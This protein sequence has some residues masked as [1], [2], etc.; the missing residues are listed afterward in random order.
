MSTY[1][2]YECVIEKRSK[3]LWKFMKLFKITAELHLQVMIHEL[4][5]EGEYDHETGNVI[6]EDSCCD[7]NTITINGNHFHVITDS[8]FL[9][10]NTTYYKTLLLPYEY[11]FHDVDEETQYEILKHN[12]LSSFKT[13]KYSGSIDIHNDCEVVIFTVSYDSSFLQFEDL[14]KMNDIDDV[15]VNEKEPEQDHERRYRV[16]LALAEVYK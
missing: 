9:D 14:L 10:P 7:N 6:Y 5:C 2:T 12:S 8:C 16:S 3:D 4:E 11:D 1:H 13:R 15:K